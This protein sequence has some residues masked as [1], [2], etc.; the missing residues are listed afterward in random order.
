MYKLLE[1]VSLGKVTSGLH[2]TLEASTSRCR[3]CS[4]LFLHSCALV[5]CCLGSIFLIKNPLGEQANARFFFPYA[6]KTLLRVV[7]GRM[8]PTDNTGRR[9]VQVEPSLA[10]LMY[11]AVLQVHKKQRTLRPFSESWTTK[12]LIG[13]D[14]RLSVRKI[15][16]PYLV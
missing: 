3:R 7:W 11:M 4:G 2:H 12:G 1:L 8:K 16:W 6:E 13:C 5:C 9:R 10:V 15:A 14:L